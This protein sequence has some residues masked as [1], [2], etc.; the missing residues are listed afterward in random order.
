MANLQKNQVSKSNV[1]LPATMASISLILSALPV[2]AHHAFTA[3]F[4]AKKP[5][6]LEGTVSKVELINPHA[7]IHVDVKT[8]DGKVTP[9]MVEAGSPNVLLRR[10]FTKASVPVGTQVV[11]DG[12][13]SKDGSMRANG[14]DITL[15]DGR[16]LF[17]GSS[18]TGA[19]YD[20][21]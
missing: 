11:V 3:E 2:R 1:W 5:V 8:A 7:W 18:G 4:D 13:Q 21:K 15:P 9:W 12:Y 6:H 20:K 10:G 17:L 14:R 19:P 16:K